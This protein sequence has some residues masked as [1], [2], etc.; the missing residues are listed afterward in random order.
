MY[1]MLNTI[2]AITAHELPETLILYPA[3]LEVA[4]LHTGNAACQSCVG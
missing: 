3:F 1:I 4:R 2:H